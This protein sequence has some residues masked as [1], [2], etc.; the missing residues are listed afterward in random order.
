M[1]RMLFIEQLKFCARCDWSITI[2]YGTQSPCLVCAISSWDQ[3]TEFKSLNYIF[4]PLIPFFFFFCK[5][6][7]IFD[8]KGYGS[9]EGTF[10]MRVNCR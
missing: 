4:S 8:S 7:L 1:R 9:L 6:I 2:D 10:E 5:N 3:G